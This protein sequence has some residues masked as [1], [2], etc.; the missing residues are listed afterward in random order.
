M[1]EPPTNDD[2]AMTKV[3][4]LWA[5]KKSEKMTQQ[6]LGMRMG[7]DQY[8]ARKSVNQFF[9]SNDPRISMLRKFA[10]AIGVKLSEIIGE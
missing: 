9:K 8:S 4:E 10:K 3:R 1:P 5:Q 2:P 6:E 7:Y